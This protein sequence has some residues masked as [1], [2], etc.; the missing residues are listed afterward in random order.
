MTYLRTDSAGLFSTFLGEGNRRFFLNAVGQPQRVREAAGGKGRKARNK[1]ENLMSMLVHRSSTLVGEKGV[2]WAA[3]W[4][5]G[6][7][8]SIA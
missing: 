4:H 3:F 5:R 7:E 6:L 2:F 8:K 1:Y